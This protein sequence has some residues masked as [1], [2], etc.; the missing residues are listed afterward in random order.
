MLERRARVMSFQVSKGRISLCEKGQIIIF[1]II[2]GQ[3]LNLMC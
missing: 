2:F 3:E 1:G